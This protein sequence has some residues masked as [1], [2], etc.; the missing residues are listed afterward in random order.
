MPDVGD[1]PL[2]LHD[3]HL[4][5][6]L[7]DQAAAGDELRRAAGL[8]YTE[9]AERVD[10]SLEDGSLLRGEVLARWQELVGTGELLRQLESRIGRARDRLIAVVR[11]RPAPGEDLAV[12]LESGVEALVLAEADRAAGRAVS[13]NSAGRSLT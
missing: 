11:G 6:D 13:V 5:A 7:D 4:V 10:A 9:A 3:P 1:R 8:P 12:A 2:D